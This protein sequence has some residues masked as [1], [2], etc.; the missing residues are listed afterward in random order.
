MVEAI[1]EGDIP[2]VQLRCR[3][4]L[5]VSVEQAWSW[6]T[7]ADRL[8]RWIAP[9][10]RVEQ[11]A[12]G[13]LH[14][15]SLSEEGTV[16]R[17]EAT[18]LE[19]SRPQRWVLAFRRLEAGWEVATRLT[20]ELSPTPEGCVLSVFQEGFEH[21]PLSECL[22]IWEA[23]RRRWRALLIRVREQPR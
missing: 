13:L 10:A 8:P 18:T 11:M 16:Q 6:I 2:G 20:L 7:E 12:E 15:E 3:R 19:I 21:L 1:R 23:Y 4:S 17:E 22:T 14:I 9:E 5:P